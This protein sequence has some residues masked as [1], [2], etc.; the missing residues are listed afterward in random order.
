MQGWRWLCCIALLSACA[1]DRLYVEGT[2]GWGS[3]DPSDKL[4]DYETESDALTV[5]LSFP[6]QS[7]PERVVVE[8][9]PWVIP[10]A[11]TPTA[12]PIAAGASPEGGAVPWEEI[13]LIAGSVATTLG[14][15]HGGKRF[16]NW[17]TSKKAGKAHC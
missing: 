5:G 8:R 6:L 12:P 4:G 15:Q 3:I 2:R 1:P 9:T 10:S 13:L 14:A 7:P 17:R 11:A 16:S